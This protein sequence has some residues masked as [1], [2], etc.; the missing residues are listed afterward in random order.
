MNKKAFK[1]FIILVLICNVW[2]FSSLASFPVCDNL[3]AQAVSPLWDGSVAAGFAG[4]TGT[5][6]DP[7]LISNGAELAY[8]AQQVNSGN[9]FSGQYIKLAQDILLNEMNEDGTFVSPTPREFTRIGTDSNLSFQGNFN[10]NGKKVI[11]LYINNDIWRHYGGLFG[12]AAAGS[13]IKNVSI[14]G[15]V[16]GGYETGGIAGYTDGVITGCEVS[17]TV[18]GEQTHIGGVAGNAGASSVISDCTVSGNVSGGRRYVGGVVGQ[19]E[20]DITDCSFDGTVTAS[21]TYVGGIAGYFAGESVVSH[22]TVSGTISGR[23]Y[24]GGVAGQTEGD[25]ADC[26]FDGTVTANDFYVG[27]IVG[28]AAGESVVSHSTVS[29]TV[30][31]RSYVGGVAGKMDKI[32]ITGCSSDCTV[33]GHDFYI[34]GVAGYAGT[35]SEISNSFVLGTAT[36][37]SYVGGVAGYTNGVITV[38]AN[39]GTVTGLEQYIGGVAGYADSLNTVNNC[40]NSGTVTA[41]GNGNRNGIGG[42][43]GGG[44]W[45]E[46]ASAIHNNLSIGSV[47]GRINVGGIV[48]ISVAPLGVQDAWHNYY[49]NAPAG[50]GVGDVWPRDGAVPVGSMFWE[51]IKDLLNSDNPAG[52]DIWSQDEN[53]IPM[54]AI[55]VPGGG[56]VV[57]VIKNSGIKEG[58]YFTVLQVGEGAAATVTSDSVFTVV[59]NMSYNQSYD[60]ETQTVGLA[61]EG[62]VVPL[63]ANTSIIMLVDGV[64]YYKNLT[65]ELGTKLALGEFIKMGSTAEHYAP[66]S[67]PAESVKEYLF[68]FDFSKTASGLPAGT[69]KVELLPVAGTFSGPMPVV[70]VAGTNAYSLTASGAAGSI[71]IDFSR[72]LAEGYDYK[73]D[74]KSYA[75]ELAL[76]QGEAN[77]SWPIGTKINGTV[78]T[79]ALPYAFTTA[80]FGSN[81]ISLDLSDCIN[82]LEEGDYCLEVRAYACNDPAS[83]REG[84]LLACGSTTLAATEPVQ[85]AIKARAVARVFDKSDSAIPVFFNIDTRG[86]GVVKSTL[87]RKYGTSYVNIADQTDLPV[88]I[89]GGGATLTVPAGYETGTY[90]FVLT[91]YDPEGHP[92]AQAEESIIVK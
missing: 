53:G 43:A 64:Y 74:G 57:G 56:G 42:I 59:F 10:G 35:G 62:T 68:I 34:G 60:P 79:S 38:C 7:Y 49:T 61:H 92:R 58:K 51:E 19:T 18:H 20:G 54:P 21:D 87:Q 4:G 69:F 78:L 23:S 11:G 47:S 81:S 63:P 52:N 88:S 13:V 15:V 41:S 24:V 90:R 6:A 77:V 75:F 3:T 40:F 2:F 44:N 39:T 83:P 45:S 66:E 32:I 67:L 27:G 82:P 26:S 72:I 48:G 46:P 65:S 73:T 5:E 55:F 86:P 70:T 9:G 1:Y 30:S 28:Y 17:C 8:F 22:S 85:Y 25:I 37:R 84:Y 16:K 89:A 76:K 91:L 80:A 12:Y 36:G 71:K 14:S 33:T 50:T 31:G 29:G